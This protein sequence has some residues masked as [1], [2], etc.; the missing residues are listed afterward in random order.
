[1]GALTDIRV[2]LT[3]AH[4]CGY[5]PD[6]QAR[7]LV[8]DPQEPALAAVYEHA[9]G[10]GF[11]RSGRHV[12]RPHC[13][14][15]SACQPIRLPVASFQPDRTQRRIAKRNADLVM[16]VAP[17]R[18]SDEHF[19]LY[20]R[21]LGARHPDSPMADPSHEEFEQFLIGDWSP[22]R[23][24]EWRLDGRLLAVAV[25]DVTANA[26][27][28][29]YTYFDPGFESRSLGTQAILGQIE[30]AKATARPHLYLGF[31]LKD[32]PKMDYKRRFRP[33]ERLWNGHWIAFD[34]GEQ[35]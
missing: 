21:Y 4:T 24:I 12:Y 13:G 20:A 17:A 26:L 16:N 6:R 18:R 9:L 15:C 2:Y 10:M 22:T 11:R 28:A 8:L 3:Q 33:M 19:E 14:T 30:W 27:S 35:E 5:W 23:F 1:M 25:T 29:V 31:W 7:D 34:D 32:H